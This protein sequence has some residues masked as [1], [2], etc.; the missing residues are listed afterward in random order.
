MAFLQL[1]IGQADALAT[2]HQRTGVFAASA[3]LFRPHSRG[4]STATAACGSERWCPPPDYN[5]LRFVERI[6][7]VSITNHIA[8]P[9]CRA[10]AWE[11]GFT[12]G[13]TSHRLVIPL[14]SWH[15]QQNPYCR[16]VTSPQ[17]NSNIL[18]HCLSSSKDYSR[19]Y[20]KTKTDA[21]LAAIL[22]AV[23]P[24]LTSSERDR[25]IRC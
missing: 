19:I 18:Q 14:F 6:D 5:R 24:S 10:I 23:F 16:C 2:K 3:T 21:D 9:C 1:F 20:H 11:S 7:D 25:C 22:C 12:S 8:G 4:S 15:G 13:L 17:H